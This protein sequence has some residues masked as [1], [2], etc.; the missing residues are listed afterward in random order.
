MRVLGV[1]LGETFS[2]LFSKFAGVGRNETFRRNLQAPGKVVARLGSGIR[3][4]VWDCTVCVGF[5]H[6]E[7]RMTA[8]AAVH[9][10]PR[11]G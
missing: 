10:A 5:S 3:K 11:G 4:V 9:G 1:G 8:T 7:T 2:N 6:L